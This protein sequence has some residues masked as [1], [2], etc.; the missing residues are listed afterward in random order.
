MHSMDE[1]GF[2]EG[3]ISQWMAAD[4][5]QHALVF[6]AIGEL[7]RECHRFLDGRAVDITS[8]LQI[9]TAA[10]FARLMELFQGIFIAVEHG[11]ISVGRI[12]SRSHLEAYFSL[13]AI[14][15]DPTFLKQYM[16]Q[17][18]RDRR[19]LVNRIRASSDPDLTALRGALDDTL[20]AE[21]NE[22]IKNEHIKPLTTEDIARRAGVHAVYA[23]AYAFLSGA[24]HTSGWDLESHVEYDD[25]DSIRKFTYGP[26]NTETDKLLAL[27][28]LLMTEALETVSSIFGEDR[29]ECCATFKHRFQALAP[30]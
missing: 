22:T 17:L 9:T 11:M 13:M 16:D 27:A 18:H 25:E 15:K 6:Q 3:R 28:G 21:I 8:D 10:L 2:L 30:K 23:T 19:S 26:S 5:D 14:H 24:V 4:R 1:N 20:I 29:S 12:V 7:N